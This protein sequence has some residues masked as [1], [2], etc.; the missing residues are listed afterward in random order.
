MQNRDVF[1]TVGRLKK[2]DRGLLLLTFFPDTEAAME[3]PILAKGSE[4]EKEQK[5]GIF[6]IGFLL[7]FIFLYRRWRRRTLSG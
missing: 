5:V 3:K 1:G 6:H 4:E 2:Y 7:P